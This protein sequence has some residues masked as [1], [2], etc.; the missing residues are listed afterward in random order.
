VKVWID[1]SNSPHPLLFAPV[2][3]RLEELGHEVLVTA[4]DAAQTLELARDRWPDVETIGGPSP[5]GRRAKAAAIAGR[6]RDLRRWAR[7]VRPDVA[8]S[9]N[10][11][12]QIAAARSL[13]VPALT[14]MD[15]EHQPANHV[16]FRLADRILLPAA[17]PA[18]AVRRQGAS[19][20]KVERYD[21]L[22]EELY[23]GDFEPD[24]SILERLGVERDGTVVV[25]MRGPP[26]RAIY[27]RFENPVFTSLLDAMAN[28][29]DVRCVVLARHPEQ[30]EAFARLAGPTFLV[31]ARALDARALMYE[32]D[33]VVGAGGTMTREAAIM[34]VPTVSVFGGKPPFVDR[35]LE[36]RGALRRLD[37]AGEVGR[38]VPRSREPRPVEELRR[39]SGAL[40]DAFA[41]ATLATGRRDV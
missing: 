15:Y 25:V 24:P 36:E 8:L 16:A 33:L 32:A 20:R 14:A 6:A 35:W 18:E 41:A 17:L 21:G 12:A 11:Y 27:H 37:G 40:V 34:G 1:L 22:K 23:I 13:G 39:R 30:R 26:S 5:P 19:P 10:S 38:V 3:R 29:E 9:H 7:R 28:Q 2:A 4:R 31:P